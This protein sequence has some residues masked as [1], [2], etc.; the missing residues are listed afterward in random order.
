MSSVIFAVTKENIH[1]RIFA[2]S[3]YTV[4]AREA[5][6][7]PPAIGERMLITADDK[8]IINPLIDDSVNEI[9]SHITRY[10]PGSSVEFNNDAYGGYYMFTVN[11]PSN[12]PGD[13]EEK[14]THCAESY[15]VNRTLQSWYTGIKPDEAAIIATKVQNDAATM[16]ILLTQ[17]KKPSNRTHEIL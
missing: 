11:T 14:L 13:N 5:M 2:N 16:Q 15:I 8:G 10:H 9:H 1:S 4:R 12:Y 6:G 17:R 3:A 7:I